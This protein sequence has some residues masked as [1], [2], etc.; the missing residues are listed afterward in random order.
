MKTTILKISAILLLISSFGAGCRNDE[1]PNHDISYDI[2]S[3]LNVFELKYG[4]L[5][6]IIYNG[7]T[8]AISIAN[9]EDSVTV[10]CSLVDFSN[11][12]DAPLSIRISSYLHIKNQSEILKVTSKPCGALPYESKG[13]D[14]LDIYELID[15]IKSAP[16]NIKDSLYFSNTFRNFFGEGTPIVD[17]PLQ[18]FIAKAFPT[19]YSHPNSSIEDYRFVFIVTIKNN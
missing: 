6:E 12:Q 17:T 4:E 15:E 16:A 13:H 5:K 1:D 14:I 8:V 10:D 19:F 11:N 18:I 7:D 2:G 3:V 9:I